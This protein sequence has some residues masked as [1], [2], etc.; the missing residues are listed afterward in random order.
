MEMRALLHEPISAGPETARANGGVGSA[1]EEGRES[2]SRAHSRCPRVRLIL[3]TCCPHP[4]TMDA[5]R[6]VIN[7]GPGPAKLPRSVS[8]RE[9]ARRVH[10]GREH[11]RGWRRVSARV[12]VHLRPGRRDPTHALSPPN[13]LHKHARPVQDRLQVGFW[14]TALVGGSWARHACA[15][16]RVR[17]RFGP[18]GRAGPPVLC[19]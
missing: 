7:F 3:L 4:C 13:V 16:A 17:A 9:R 15:A 19:T 6:Q 12:A 11:K 18:P 8:P 2:A 1:L 10:P 14:K 5:P